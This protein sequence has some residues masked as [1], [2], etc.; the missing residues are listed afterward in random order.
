MGRAGAICRFR[1]PP[2]PDHI[3]TTVWRRKNRQIEE[4][5]AGTRTTSETQWDSTTPTIA[6]M[7]KD[8][9]EFEQKVPITLR[10]NLKRLDGGYNPKKLL[11]TKTWGDEGNGLSSSADAYKKIADCVSGN[12][13]KGKSKEIETRKSNLCVNVN[14]DKV[15]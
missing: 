8:V 14:S 3:S 10:V 13:V 6:M 9:D 4:G 12:R 1:K 2:S 11:Q 7:T 15:S 5:T